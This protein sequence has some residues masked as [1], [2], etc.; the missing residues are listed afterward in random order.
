MKTRWVARFDPATNKWR[1]FDLIKHEW[2]LGIYHDTQE[3]AERGA[4]FANRA[5]FNDYA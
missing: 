4:E 5:W 3:H 1:I 2:T